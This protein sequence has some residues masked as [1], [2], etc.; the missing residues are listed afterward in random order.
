[1]LICINHTAERPA[2]A[3]YNWPFLGEISQ[4]E[5][6]L[7][8]L[9]SARTISRGVAYDTGRWKT[10]LQGRPLKIVHRFVTPNI[11]YSSRRAKLHAAFLPPHR[12]A[13]ASGKSQLLSAVSCLSDS[14]FMQ[15]SDNF[16]IRSITWFV[17]FCP[18]VGRC[19]RCL[20]P[21]QLGMF[22]FARKFSTHTGMRELVL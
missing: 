17:V 21:D 7:P 8:N 18:C 4:R 6:L 12:R 22:E 2:T 3:L 1:M 5:Q 10:I 13:R 16:K 11:H 20:L 9:C 14:L 15:E 19:S